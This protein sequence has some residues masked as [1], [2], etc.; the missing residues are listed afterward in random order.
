VAQTSTNPNVVNPNTTGGDASTVGGISVSAD[1]TPAWGE[2]LPG[3]VDTLIS[4]IV[5]GQSWPDASERLLWALAKEHQA[6]GE[7]LCGAVEPSVAACRAVLSG[8]DV[9]ATPAFLEEAGRLFS[10]ES[11]VA[12]IGR[13]H[14]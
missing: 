12:E 11:G 13:A 14:V 2:D 7:G 10:Q 8:W 4:M 3:W 6:L 5:S 9:P 1:V